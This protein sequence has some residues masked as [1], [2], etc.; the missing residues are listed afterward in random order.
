LRSSGVF[1]YKTNC[2]FGSCAVPYDGKKSEFRLISAKTLELRNTILQA[3]ERYNT[4][5]V[6]TVKPGVLFVSDM[7]AAD[8][9]SVNFYRVAQKK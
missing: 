1:D 3:C 5:W 2:I 4:E 9:V 6:N 7:P 8:V